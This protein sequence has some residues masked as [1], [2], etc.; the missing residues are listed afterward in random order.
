VK[1]IRFMTALALV[2]AALPVRAET[3]SPPAS[4]EIGDL[5]GLLNEN[6][7]TTA[8][9]T[10][11]TGS[12][13][14]A[15]SVTLTAEDL[16]RYGIHTVAEAIDFLSL[17]GNVTE[18]GEVGARG[19]V[20]ADDRGSH[21]L[22]LV[23]GHAAN[24]QL[25]GSAH[26]DRGLGMP[27]EMI[28]HIEFIL[29]P[30]SVLYGSNA[31][32]GV[33]NIVTKSASAA[34]GTYVL[35]ES[36]LANS[37]RAGAGGGYE[38][39]LFG[40]PSSLTFALEYFQKDGPSYTLPYQELAADVVTGE[41]WRVGRHARAG[42]WG[43]PNDG[44]SIR[45][46]SGFVR[47]KWRDLEVNGGASLYR[48]GALG[49]HPRRLEPSGTD[50]ND[51]DNYSNELRVWMDARQR[52][53]LSDT[54]ELV[55]R[56]YAD[57]FELRRYNDVSATYYCPYAGVSTC[58]KETLGVSRWAGSEVQLNLDW[59]QDER[60]TTLIGV[61][62]RVRYA[63]HKIDH[64]DYDTGQYLESSSSVF[65]K[66]D[67]VIGAYAQQTWQPS[68]VFGLNAGA[69]LDA[70][71]AFGTHLSPR[72]ASTLALWRGG[73]LKAVYSEAYRAPTWYEAELTNA[74]Q[75]K[76]K[77]LDPETVRSVELSLD[78]KLGTHR[79]TFG[80]FRSWW[81]SLIQL[82]ALSLEE[83]R[84]AQRS[85]EAPFDIFTATQ[86]RNVSSID[87]YGYNAGYEGTLAG[88]QLH[89]GL[90]VTEAFSRQS[91]PGRDA[92]PVPLSP[93]FF[94]NARVAYT[95]PGDWPTLAVAA[96]YVGR[97][98]VDAALD[99]TFGVPPFAK[100]QAE[101]RGTVSGRV[102]A[103]HALS[104]RVSASY[105]FTATSAYAAGVLVAPNPVLLPVDQFRVTAGL[106]YDF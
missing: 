90:N 101:L 83:L 9:K 33:L 71:T 74:G 42:Y 70:Y 16:R 34:G 26:F 68:R 103:L 40:K 67:A 73:I 32:F 69:R 37:W 39:Q 30:G 59:F 11:Q 82:Q 15:T 36:E 46:P 1:A 104:Y 72:L 81:S 106:Q 97:R 13:A 19:L 25:F 23:N 80:G 54:A 45:I 43:G 50:Y 88:G 98:A 78:Q 20:V 52:A 94:G 18:G 63:G 44:D 56:A 92:L 79:L 58:R 62:G 14:P 28:D 95:L 85:G 38:F 55:V 29:G 84:E 66:T 89:L 3:A 2:T 24:E 102:P 64:T 17:G 48:L 53:R 10:A 91:L 7:V 75:I 77:N 41:P 60:F 49:G 57:S 5:E 12:S 8:S 96:R 51:P 87:S 4:A 86:F 76:A 22:L 99:P 35:A 21:V 47:F 27:L 65:T 105:S 93:T 6:I 61:D 100:P 31:M